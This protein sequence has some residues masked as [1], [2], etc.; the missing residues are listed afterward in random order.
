MC[1]NFNKMNLK[2]HPE[3]TNNKKDIVSIASNFTSSGKMFADGKRNKIKLFLINN[4]TINVKGF[5]IPILLNQI[6]Y[7][8]FRESKARRSYNYATILLEKGIGTPQPIAYLENK[9]IFGLQ[10]SYY[11][12]EHVDADLT[13]RELVT[14]PD[15]ENHEQ[16]LRDFTIFCLQLHDNGIEFKDHSPGNTLVKKQP[17]GS[18]KFYLVDL[19][20]MNFHD[21]MSFEL[22]M[23]NLSRLTPKKDMIAVMSNEYAKYYLEKTEAEIFESMWNETETFQAKFHKKQAL[24][25]KLLNK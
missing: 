25:K 4:E 5:K 8:Y 16:I 11:F 14:Y 23:K 3:Y 18:Y 22:R 21:Q 17:D 12:S 1:T 19:N 6:I 10:D 9:N 24:K 15:W 13:F 7:G 20:R 2:I